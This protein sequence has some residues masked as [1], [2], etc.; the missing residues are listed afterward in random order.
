MITAAV[1]LCA[2]L[3][4]QGCD[5]GGPPKRQGGMKDPQT[6]AT[7]L[8]EARLRLAAIAVERSSPDEALALLVAAL[9]ADP[10]SREALE[11]AHAILRETR[12][13]LA[14]KTLAHPGA[15]E[16]LHFPNPSSLWVGLE[17]TL[18]RWD[19]EALE[20][21]ATLFPVDLPDNKFRSLVADAK[22]QY[23][24]IERAGFALLCDAMTLKPIEDIGVLPEN[25]TPSAVV[26]FS[27]DGLLLAHPELLGDGGLVWHLRDSKTGGILRSSE[28]AAAGAPAPLAAWLDR[29]QLRVLHADGSLME[30]PVSPAEEIRM[31]PHQGAI[32]LSHAVFARNGAAALVLRD[33][34]PHQPAA[35][36]T[37]ELG[38]AADASLEPASLLQTHPWS[39]H[40]TLWSG[41]FKDPND[42]LLWVED[43]RVDILTGGYA[44]VHS[45]SPVTALAMHDDRIAVGE[46]NGTVTLHLALPAPLA[47]TEKTQPASGDPL[48]LARLTAFLAGMRCAGDGVSFETLNT[49][50]RVQ[51]FKDCDFPA[52]RRMFPDL[53]FAPVVAALEQVNPKTAGPQALASFRG[54]MARAKQAPEPD[55]AAKLQQA[56]MSDQAE[57]IEACLKE[58]D[59]FPPLLKK[60]AVSRIA[61]LQDRKADAMALWPDG[62]PDLREVRLREDWEGWEHVDFHQ[63]METLKAGVNEELEALAV[64]QNAT[65]EQRAEVFKRL[66][67]ANTLRIVGRA[68]LASACLEAARAFSAFSDE[69]QNTLQLASLARNLGEDP[70]RCLRAEAMA[71]TAL[72]D[73]ENA[74]QRWLMLITDYAVAFHEPGDYAEAAY[75]AFENAD[76]HQA[77]VIL[78]TGLHRFPDDANFALRAGWVSL[79]TGNAE[80]AYRFLLTGRQIGYPQ[81]KVENATALLAIAASQTGAMEDAEVFYQE[82]IDLDPAWQNPETIDSL[83]WPEELKS[84]LRQWVAGP[85][86]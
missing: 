39:R 85:P 69:T 3:L 41:L 25:V 32:Q 7:G 35:R 86:P 43:K 23:L 72:G 37:L 62:F 31:I 77:M 18:T 64:P 16:R 48:V 79:L 22:S 5:T 38:A 6:L 29:K 49:A 60:L 11:M 56:L 12:W 28:P 63:A 61:W 46:E 13:I 4:F 24:V 75:T 57:A 82:L 26:A 9:E 84:S 14:V 58:S 10:S 52:L 40:P 44:P 45:D 51:A 21:R 81:E 42:T 8:A 76:P 54:R 50:E 33:R 74:H 78:T 59:Y 66:T 53:D 71:Y 67:D 15:I 68:R 36:E 80:R 20:C 70:A 2:S 73:Y 47:L 34:G 1:C 65:A 17:G 27:S 55:P 30:M 83:E 19:L